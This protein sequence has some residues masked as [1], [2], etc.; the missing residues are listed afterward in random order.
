MIL[1]SLITTGTFFSRFGELIVDYVATAAAL[2][3][4]VEGMLSV[5]KYKDEKLRFQS[6]RIIRI[7]IGVC[8]VTI[9]FWQFIQK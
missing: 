5:R 1:A 9:H 8:I 7:L 6:L 4:I 2:F 3:L